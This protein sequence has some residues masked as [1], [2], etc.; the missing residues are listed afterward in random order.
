MNAPSVQ[1]TPRKE[2]SLSFLVLKLLGNI[3]LSDEGR[4]LDLEHGP[5]MLFIINS[6]NNCHLTAMT[7][8]VI[9]ALIH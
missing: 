2:P 3:F 7:V 5:G 1:L 4:G 6:D 9:M 8:T